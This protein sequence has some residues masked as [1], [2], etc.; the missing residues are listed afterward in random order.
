M[1][2][3]ISIC[4]YALL[5][6]RNTSRASATRRPEEGQSVFPSRGKQSINFDTAVGRSHN[7]SVAPDFGS[8]SSLLLAQSYANNIVGTRPLERKK[9]RNMVSAM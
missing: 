3:L 9:L 8:I 4:V 6:A 1:C 5:Q 2:I 7:V